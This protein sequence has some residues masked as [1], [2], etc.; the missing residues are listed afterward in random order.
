MTSDSMKGGGMT[1]SDENRDARLDALRSRVK[2]QLSKV[3]DDTELTVKESSIVPTNL[4]TQIKQA[5]MWLEMQDKDADR[6]RNLGSIC[7]LIG[8]I[9]GLISG[10]LILQGNPSELLSTSLFDTQNSVDISGL[11]IYEDDAH[12]ASEVNITLMELDSRIVLQETSTDDYGYYALENIAPK[13]HILKFEKDGYETVE[14]Q[15]TPDNAGMADLTLRGGDGIRTVIDEGQSSG[16]TLDLQVG[17]SS[18]IGLLTI[19]AA[20][21]GVQ[22]SVEVRRGKY[23]RRTQY[24]S[25]F[26]LFSRG[27]IIFGP[28]L[29]LL[30]M[31]IIALVK[32]DFDDQR[33][34]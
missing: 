7:I 1:V 17:M 23:Y 21:V 24:L 14:W 9:L 27:L 2:Q 16:W 5:E 3:E 11:V 4:H 32:D 25:G 15:F 10:F 12:G 28:T 19:F 8:S 30:G 34:D 13:P 31:I 18:T 6:W 26:A 20:L 33:D 29:I 22:A